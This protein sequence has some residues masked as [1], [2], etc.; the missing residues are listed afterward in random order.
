VKA[1][2]IFGKDN[3]I[4]IMTISARVDVIVMMVVVMDILR[5]PIIIS[6]IVVDAM[7]KKK[8]FFG[9]SVSQTSTTA[10]H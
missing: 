6:R 5:Q 2:V 9:S 4:I 3:I 10:N 1:L 8:S 7:L